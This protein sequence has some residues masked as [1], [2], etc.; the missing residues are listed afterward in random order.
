MVGLDILKPG[1]HAHGADQAGRMVVVSRK[2]SR[3]K[4]IGV[5]PAQPAWLVAKAE[6]APSPSGRADAKPGRRS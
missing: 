4:L 5:F 6:A 2:I 3:G 1:F